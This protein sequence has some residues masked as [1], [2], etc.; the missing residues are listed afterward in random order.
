MKLL[1]SLLLT[2]T[3]VSSLDTDWLRIW[4][5][6]RA[7]P[8][9]RSPGPGCLN[10]GTF[11]PYREDRGFCSCPEQFQGRKCEIDVSAQCYNDNGGYYRGTASL[12]QSGAECLRW[13]HVDA[14][15]A[16]GSRALALGIG[17]HNYCRN[18]DRSTRPW[19]MV[20]KGHQ[21]VPEFCQLQ[22]CGEEPMTMCGERSQK[23][24]KIVGGKVTTVESHP[25]IAAIYY[26]SRTYQE[27]W[28]R[29]GGSLISPCW[30]LT[31]AHCF[32]DGMA[33]SI[34]RLSVSLGKNAINETNKYREQAFQ[35]E[36]L[37]IHEN[38]R[39]RDENY[40]HDIALLRL[41][42]RCAESTKTVRTICL[43]PEHQ[44]LPPGT[45]CDVAGYG[46]EKHTS[47]LYSQV[48]KEAKVN[49]MSQS[50]CTNKQHYGDK[51]TENMFCANS[52]DW[53]VDSCKGD[54]GGPLVCE[55]DNRMFLF[56]IVSWGEGCS[57]KYRPGVY[58]KVTN[59][60]RWIEENTGLSTITTGSMY[61]QK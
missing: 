10:G 2:V 15:F 58:T 49:I 7:N 42:G 32:P 5:L 20:Q 23:L 3:A 25:W 12:S 26:K 6:M 21:I 37:I 46:K 27:N 48:L 45:T 44:M 34:N 33:T 28:F 30:V 29:C 52:P 18:P 14:Q 19:C 31:A 24:F 1:L 39:Y 36:R 53:T 51:V 61:P 9:D 56:G 57:E 38:Y 50:V 40:N 43:P 59:Y 17:K 60:N 8:F 16:L 47:S 54:S 11:V 55:V 41:K 35:V 22:R 13:D 4:K